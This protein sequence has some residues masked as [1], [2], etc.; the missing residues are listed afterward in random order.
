MSSFIFDFDFLIKVTITL[1]AGVLIGLERETRGKP[2]DVSTH[3]FVIGGSMLFT[4][5]SVMIDPS[6]PARVAA[7]IVTGIGFL[8]AGIIL[9]K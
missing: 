9:I 7:Q 3:A 4:V 2:A 5:L 1:V 6:E 8:G